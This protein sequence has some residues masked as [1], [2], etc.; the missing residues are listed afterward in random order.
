[1]S[2]NKAEWWQALSRSQLSRRLRLEHHEFKANERN[3]KR[4]CLK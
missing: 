3:L 1:M 4:A 2:K